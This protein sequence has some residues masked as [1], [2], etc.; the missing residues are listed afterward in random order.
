MVHTAPP[1]HGLTAQ[2]CCRHS[3]MTG[4]KTEDIISTLQSLHMIKFWKGQ[5]R[6]C[7]GEKGRRRVS[8]PC[9]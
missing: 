8:L 9:S 3:L 1:S 2:R 5:V 4:F 7:S 6:A